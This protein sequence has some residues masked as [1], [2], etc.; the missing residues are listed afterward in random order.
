M[1]PLIFRHAANENSIGPYIDFVVCLPLG[2]AVGKLAQVGGPSSVPGNKSVFNLM[3][4]KFHVSDSTDK[5]A[6][7]CLHLGK[8]HLTYDSTFLKCKSLKYKRSMYK[9]LRMPPLHRLSSGSLFGASKLHRHRWDCYLLTCKV[10]W[11]SRQATKQAARQPDSQ[12]A[13]QAAATS[14]TTTSNTANPKATTTVT[15]Q[16]QLQDSTQ[17]TSKQGDNIQ[18]ETSQLPHSCQGA[19]PSCQPGS[20]PVCMS[21]WPDCTAWFLPYPLTAPPAPLTLVAS[22]SSSICLQ[23]CP[24]WQLAAA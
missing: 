14:I 16:T 19:R 4:S 21:V 9:E 2:W 20:P 5:D 7:R 11:H 3:C 8:S 24:L 22:S 18:L 17:L 1:A 10:H 6:D 15:V 13:S 23:H 12:P